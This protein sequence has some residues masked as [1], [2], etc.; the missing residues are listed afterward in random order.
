M[1]TIDI[2]AHIGLLSVIIAKKIG[3]NGRCYS[4]EPT[5]ST[6]NLLK[7][8]IRINKL[9][10]IIVPHQMAVSNTVGKVKFYITDVEAHNSNTLS[11]GNRQDSS[12]HAVEVDV[13]TIDKIVQQSNISQLGFL[14]IDAEGAEYAVLKG[15]EKTIEEF[16]PLILLAIHPDFVKNFGD[17]LSE[18]WDFLMRHNYKVIYKSDAINKEFFINQTDMFDVH[19]IPK[20]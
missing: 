14:K 17:S 4:F 12:E 2:G 18:I 6:Y 3:D 10:D 9:Q 20:N 15:G 16:H 8:T 11:V 13:T 7:Q 1:Q 5:P 19:L